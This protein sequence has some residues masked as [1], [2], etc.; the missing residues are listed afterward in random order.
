MKHEKRKL[1]KGGPEKN[2]HNENKRSNE[3]KI[4]VTSK[5]EN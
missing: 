4:R 1:N 5:I 2:V 3:Q